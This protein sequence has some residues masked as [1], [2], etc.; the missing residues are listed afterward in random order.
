MEYDEL[1]VYRSTTS[2][3]D[4]WRWI[5]FGAGVVVGLLVAR[6]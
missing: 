6:R 3:L 4:W 2:A 1:P 5:F